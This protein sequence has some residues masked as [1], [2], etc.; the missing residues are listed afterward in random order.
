MIALVLSYAGILLV[1]AHD[2]RFAGDATGLWL[3][4]ALVLLDE[5]MKVRAERSAGTQ[6]NRA[7]R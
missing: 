6:R 1:F 3:G 5:S 7:F 4:G 2:L